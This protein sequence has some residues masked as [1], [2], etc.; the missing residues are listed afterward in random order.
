VYVH[1]VTNFIKKRAGA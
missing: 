1:N